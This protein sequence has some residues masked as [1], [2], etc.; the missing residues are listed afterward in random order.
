M[1]QPV[2]LNTLLPPAAAHK[3]GQGGEKAD[4]R[5]PLRHNGLPCFCPLFPFP[6]INKDEQNIVK[7]IFVEEK[8]EKWTG[9]RHG[10]DPYLSS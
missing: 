4:T 5:E 7:K 10:A 3:R 2:T 1:Q 6:V 9:C 8:A